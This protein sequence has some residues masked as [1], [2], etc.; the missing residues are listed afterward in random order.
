[1]HAPQEHLGDGEREGRLASGGAQR[2]AAAEDLDGAR[3]LPHDCAVVTPPPWLL[4]WLEPEP[5]LLEPE[6]ELPESSLCV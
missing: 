1:V 2:D 3:V 4:L 6:S 5:A